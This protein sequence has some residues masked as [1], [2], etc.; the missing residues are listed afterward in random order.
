MAHTSYDPLGGDGLVP[1]CWSRLGQ[2]LTIPDRIVTV[3]GY[4]VW[5]F[6]NPTG[7]ITFTI[8]NATT[9]G[10]MV[11]KVWGDAS[12]L[13]SWD[14]PSDGPAR[15]SVTLD[16]P[17][18]I[19]GEVKICVE[20]YGGNKTDFCGAGYYAGDR[21]TGEYYVNYRYGSW[22]DIGEAE[23]GAYYYEYIDKLSDI[24]GEAAFPHWQ[25]LMVIPIGASIYF[26]RRRIKGKRNL[27]EA[28]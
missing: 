15:Q 26:V 10:L 6:G 2:R 25:F 22:I 1:N 9:N 7:N 8:Y 13:T 18:R 11:S 20:Y 12:N 16:E 17:I 5:K 3:I 23:E 4:S 28:A 14:N 24:T 19:N 27:N 21:I